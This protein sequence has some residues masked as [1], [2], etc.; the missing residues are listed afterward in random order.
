MH[1]TI[2]WLFHCYFASFVLFF[3]ILNIGILLGLAVYEVTS[4][5]VG[6]S[7]QQKA[8]FMGVVNG[9]SIL[10]GMF[11]FWCSVFFFLFKKIE[12]FFALKE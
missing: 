5:K 4:I 12:V 11:T 2:A 1:L 9:I 6:L 10:G 8:Q 7:S 3:F